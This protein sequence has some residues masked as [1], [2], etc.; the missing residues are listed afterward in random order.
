[1]NVKP[2]TE[3]PFVVTTTGA[4]PLAFDGAVV[5]IIVLLTTV[6]LIPATLLNVTVA[7][8]TKFVPVIVTK[9]PVVPLG[10]DNEVRVG[11]GPKR[12]VNL[13]D[14][15]TL[16]PVWSVTVTVA[17][18]APPGANG[19]TITDRLLSELVTILLTAT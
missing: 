15:C 16:L 10:G 5:V 19:G 3:V 12:Y 11:G 4:G 8:E 7:G 14:D 17:G 2:P 9:V 1:V 6:V 18:F 13:F